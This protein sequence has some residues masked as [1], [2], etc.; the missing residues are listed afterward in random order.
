MEEFGVLSGSNASARAELY[1]QWIDA[2]GTSDVPW[3]FWMFGA[4]NEYKTQTYNVRVNYPG[5]E[6]VI[7]AELNLEFNLLDGSHSI[8]GL[9]YF[10]QRR[11]QLNQL[12][13]LRAGQKSGSLNMSNT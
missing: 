5:F 1:T 3:H 2:A 4:Y 9:R 11:Y 13:V 6:Q 7:E 10:H 8:R 12:P